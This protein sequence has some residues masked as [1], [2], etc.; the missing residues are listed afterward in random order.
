MMADFLSGIIMPERKSAI[1]ISGSL[2]QREVEWKERAGGR[3]E[4]REGEAEAERMK[5]LKN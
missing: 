2:Y 5:C 1:S 4:E 3:E